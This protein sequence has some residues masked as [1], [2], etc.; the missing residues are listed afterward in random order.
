MEQITRNTLDCFSE[1]SY[2]LVSM[3]SL[4]Q[5]LYENDT[6]A[7]HHSSRIPELDLYFL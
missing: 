2:V 4:G 6:K 5:F 3:E 7:L 1:A